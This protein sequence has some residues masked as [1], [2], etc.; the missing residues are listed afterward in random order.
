VKKKKK[1]RKK[2]KKKGWGCQQHIAD[3]KD[4]RSYYPVITS[5]AV[6]T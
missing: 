4:G 3:M 6:F 1:K 5:C 2:E